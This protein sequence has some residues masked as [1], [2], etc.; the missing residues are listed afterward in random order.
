M[1]T[2]AQLHPLQVRKYMKSIIKP[3]I[4]L[5]DMC[6]TL[7]NTVRRLIEENGLDA[8]GPS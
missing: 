1:R 7:E 4:L 6:E 3:G 2:S 8:G 5:F